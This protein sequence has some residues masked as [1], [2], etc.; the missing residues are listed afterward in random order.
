M[1]IKRD[2]KIIIDNISKL[3]REA[4]NI[5][6][7]ISAK[8][9]HI[10]FLAKIHDDFKNIDNQRQLEAYF[11]SKI[12]KEY[13][14]SFILNEIDEVN[15]LIEKYNQLAKEIKEYNNLINYCL[16]NEV[17]NEFDNFIN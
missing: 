10:N 15:K 9:H 5:D 13:L 16:E 4:N 3:K 6:M 8:K 7:D 12:D 17:K 14:Y 1:F 2:Y 11:K